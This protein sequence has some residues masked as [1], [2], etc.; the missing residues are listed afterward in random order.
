MKA[1]VNL[2]TG[3][4]TEAVVR[5]LVPETQGDIPKVNIDV[6]NVGNRL[7]MEIEA[8]SISSLRA[9]LNSFL[10]WAQCAHEVARE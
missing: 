4:A 7:R 6:K 9:C 5:A 8:E 1:V 3:K 10:G 2:R